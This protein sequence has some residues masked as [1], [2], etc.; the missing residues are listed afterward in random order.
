MPVMRVLPGATARGVICVAGP[1]LMKPRCANVISHSVVRAPRAA[2]ARSNVAST[3][4]G[5]ANRDDAIEGL[6][7]IVERVSLC[8]TRP[9]S[10]SVTPRGKR[11]P[12]SAVRQPL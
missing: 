4:P 9:S 12:L 7:R 3:L 6:T 2:S 5:I 10:A 8:S 11:T 1:S